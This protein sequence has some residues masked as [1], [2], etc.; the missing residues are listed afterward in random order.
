MRC[1]LVASLLTGAIASLFAVPAAASA[2]V[3]RPD[4]ATVA[5]T[6]TTYT[7]Q[8]PVL[9]QVENGPWTLSQGDPSLAPYTSSYPTYST[10]GSNYLSDGRPNLAVYPDSTTG[11]PA[12]YASGVAGTS[13]PLPG[14]CTS[15]G[16]APESGSL[17]SEPANTPLPMSPYYFPDVVRNADGS[18][19][20]YFDYRPKDAEE[21]IVAA[22][23]T[24]NGDSWQFDGMA[25]A[26][27]PTNYCPTGDTNDNGQ[28]HPYVASFGGSSLLYTVNRPAGD[29]PGVGLLVHSLDPQGGNPLAGLN[30]EESVGTDP[31][32]EATAAV[33]LN[34]SGGTGLSVPVASLNTGVEALGAG[35]YQD[36]QNG[37][38][39]SC[40]SVDSAPE[41]DS[42]TSLTAGTVT[43]SA[44][45]TLLA[46]LTQVSAPV[47][48]PQGPNN[49]VDGTATGNPGV[50]ITVSPDVSA[51]ENSNIPGRVYVDGATVY[52]ANVNGS[53]SKLENCTTTQAGGVSVNTN[54]VIT[55]DPIL[56]TD[57]GQA[58]GPV[59]T[60]GLI[61]PDG[62][63]G[64]L[65]GTPAAY[66]SELT[67]G[68]SVVLYTEKVLNY[69]DSAATTA[70]VK[71]SGS[72]LSS[73]SISATG[74][75]GLGDQSLG[76]PN[77]Y[78]LSGGSVTLT[79]GTVVT[80]TSAPTFVTVSCTGASA[81]GFSGCSF[82]SD[83][84]GVAASALT[85]VASGSDI[86][87]PGAATASSTT[88]GLIGE[89]SSKPTS[90]FKNNEDLTVLRAAETSNGINFTDLGPISGTN[91][92]EDVNNPSQT[93]NP[94]GANTPA[95]VAV[96]SP[97]STEMR[98]VG[99]RGT[100][101][102]NPDGSYGMFLSGA[103]E[104]DGDSDAF[105]QIFYTS[106]TDGEHWSVPVSVVSTDYTFAARA[107]LEDG[108]TSTLGISAYYSGRAYSPSVVENPDG[109]LTMVFS[110]YGSPKP[111]PSVGSTLGGWTVGADDPAL[112][113]N[114]LT[115]T[116]DPSTTSPVGTSTSLEVT[117]N[118]VD[119][120]STA[121]YTAT[122]TSSTGDGTPT[123]TV[124]IA[125]AN[126]TICQASLD[127]GSPDT[128]SCTGTYTS[129][130]AT[131]SVTATYS[132]D[133]IFEGSVSPAASVTIDALDST[134]SVT[135]LADA[136]SGTPVTS[137]YAG[138]EVAVTAEV[139]PADS[140]DT[141][142]PTGT[143]SFTDAETGDPLCSATVSAGAA[144]CDTTFDTVGPDGV[145]ASYSGDS[146]FA[147]STATELDFYV[148]RSTT[149]TE[150][151]ST[152]DANP[153]VGESVT[154]TAT[155]SNEA[156]APAPTGTVEFTDALSGQVV[157]AEP[158]SGASAS[159][160]T[161][162]STAG[163][164]S[165][166]A[167]YVGDGSNAGST[168]PSAGEDV[169]QAATTLAI[170]ATPVSLVTGEAIQLTGTVTVQAPGAGTPSG[171]V[172]FTG[173]SGTLCV[174]TLV[175]STPDTATCDAAYAG[176]AH[177]TVSASYSGDSNF[178]GASSSNTDT[179]TVTAASTTTTLV[180]PT[181]AIAYGEDATFTAEVSPVAPGAG[182]PTGV[183][184][185]TVETSS[186]TSLVCSG[187]TAQ[188]LSGG[189]ASCTI[190]GDLTTPSNGPLTVTLTYVGSTAFH[191]STS[192]SSVAI[193][194]AGTVVAL[195]APANG[196]AGQA[197][198]VSATVT[199]AAPFSGA[200][201]GGSVTFSVVPATTGTP[202]VAC[203]AVPVSKMGGAKCTLPAG[204][205]AGGYSVVAA[206]SG[207][208]ND[209]A[210]TAESTLS[211]KGASKTAV[212]V[213]Q[214]G[215][216]V[217][218][219][220]TV[221]GALAGGVVPTGSVTFT[222]V[223][224]HGV[225]VT[226]GGTNGV[227]LNSA[228]TAT[229][230]LATSAFVPDSEPYTVTATYSGGTY[231]KTSSGKATYAG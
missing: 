112:Y 218:F 29:N 180:A 139:A 207:S 56:P 141:E 77:A 202:E 98:Y 90:L 82:V 62:I 157:C 158:L 114:I 60:T 20:G 57:Y 39:F 113:R 118:P 36:Y 193:A 71:F 136:A 160:T 140:V 86:G 172:T 134:T 5:Q 133:W 126:G 221:T 185:F 32:T 204:L 78:A 123:G 152:T 164:D 7:P 30:A 63:V 15:G 24:T 138:E 214:S 55:S 173:Q 177:D 8:S 97:D 210:A 162:F 147:S 58:N 197:L 46:A 53:G 17:A 203:A 69:Y 168:S 216:R 226:C 178:T 105:N 67:P 99:S 212:T 84:A 187:G 131:D 137:P 170:S 75:L 151:T 211:L 33:T 101:I 194:P 70:T 109:T 165:I 175:V 184:V 50:T 42:C 88:L 44:G 196:S 89:G 2:A 85:T 87:A 206:Y 47:T 189:V 79:L 231:Y 64:V 124:T 220:A 96:G 38:S 110:G 149:T 146:T 129:A 191:G 11:S 182:T 224:K 161:A 217:T 92:Y 14:Y 155:V 195:T 145:D 223:G 181:T 230:S 150:I 40:S 19:T 215:T 176:P 27:N 49:E 120:D 25:L 111:L 198:K 61:A 21:A 106:S 122:V 125:D 91:P 45:D 4:L 166:T 41:L 190:G 213:A 227:S 13:G 135:G 188:P 10:G 104:N 228:G 159:C 76:I 116:L 174:A 171:T 74:A 94:E 6:A 127:E 219:S 108:T 107:A 115:V 80:A 121:T 3:L 52:C 22:T 143:V 103:W 37:E 199:L 100:I 142:S 65:P 130:P 153:V 179:V 201:G 1:R 144:T 66:A 73:T 31:D 102:V 186:G 117:P 209:A 154:L 169:T 208:T 51:I 205:P 83:T 167:Y 18:L 35:V 16:A 43:I 183:V 148:N 156:G 225:V 59:Q 26:E 28:G 68:D 48:I 34:P 95:Y 93:A 23:S 128:A 132:G 81:S 72:G 222:A 163:A 12:A 119:V 54:D 200:V 192:R 9:D 229:C